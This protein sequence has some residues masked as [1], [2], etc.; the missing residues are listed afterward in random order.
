MSNNKSVSYFDIYQRIIVGFIGGTSVLFF[1]LIL[2]RLYFLDDLPM[3]EIIDNF[4]A[5]NMVLHF[6]ALTWFIL[7]SV[8]FSMRQKEARKLEEDI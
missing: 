5:V 1:A 2:A 6:G 3:R 8:T 7:R 4:Q